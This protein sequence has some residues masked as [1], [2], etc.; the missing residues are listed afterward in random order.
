MFSQTLAPFLALLAVTT[1]F[2][3]VSSIP[4]DGTAGDILARSTK[5]KAATPSPPHFVVYSDA[6][7]SGENGPPATSQV[8][9]SV[10]ESPLNSTPSCN[11]TISPGLQRLVRIL[12]RI[13]DLFL[14]SYTALYRSF[15]QKGRMTRRKSGF[16]SVPLHAPQSSPSTTPQGSS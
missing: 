5:A 14:T 16:K 2:S 6:W 3:L 9:V 7:V 1:Q 13:C 4:L 11:S 15:L 8:Q 10:T 12:N